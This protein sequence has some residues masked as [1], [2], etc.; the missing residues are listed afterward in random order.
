MRLTVTLMRTYR[1]ELK[2]AHTRVAEVET[3]LKEQVRMGSHGL[4]SH[5]LGSHG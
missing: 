1:E 2:H 3:L 4:G 5:G